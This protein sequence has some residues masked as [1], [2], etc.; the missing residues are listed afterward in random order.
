MP[1]IQLEGNCCYRCHHVWLS[2]L[3]PGEEA[4]R[5]IQGKWVAGKRVLP[6]RCASCKD[7]YWNRRRQYHMRA[8][9]RKP[10][11]PKIAV[12]DQVQDMSGAEIF[13]AV[14]KT[15]KPKP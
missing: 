11:K 2:E 13:D 5:L 6:E 4:A 12:V 10:R 3:L 8:G 15:V 7:P 1:K 9:A 14:M